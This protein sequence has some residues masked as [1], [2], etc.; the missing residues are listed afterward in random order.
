MPLNALYGSNHSNGSKKNPTLAHKITK[1]TTKINQYRQWI[2]HLL[3][4]G[5]T[6]QVPVHGMSMFPVLLPGD[7]VQ[8]H[9]IPFEKLKPGQVLVFESNNQW[10]AHRLISK[11]NHNREL[12]TKGD[13]LNWL[14]NNVP[15]EKAKGVVTKVIKT[16]SPLAWSINTR[17][18]GFMVW[19]GPVLGKVFWVAG[20]I[21]LRVWR[22]C[23]S[24]R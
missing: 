14:D 23:K 16:R 21:V 7:K 12:I 11:D 18:D 4:E 2:D 13:G 17:V 1:V 20:R 15:A 5:K 9:R 8:V 19:A 3:S 24:L 22:A 10:V 6:V